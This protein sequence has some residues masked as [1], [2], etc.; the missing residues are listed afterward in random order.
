[1]KM[2]ENL[3]YGIIIIYIHLYGLI[4]HSH[5]VFAVRFLIKGIAYESSGK[6]L[7][8]ESGPLQL[9]CKQQP[10][11]QAMTDTGSTTNTHRQ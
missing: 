3:H 1:M 2:L 9:Q 4:S 5:F 7:P 11:T 6:A 10:S 8:M